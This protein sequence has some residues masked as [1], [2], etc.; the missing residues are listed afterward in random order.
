MKHGHEPAQVS[1]SLHLSL[2]QSRLEII[3]IAIGVLALVSLLGII[4]FL[5][6]L[7]RLST[8][9][10]HIIS[11]KKESI[12]VLGEAKRSLPEEK[13]TFQLEDKVNVDGTR[14]KSASIKG[15]HRELQ[16]LHRRST[17][18]SGHEISNEYHQ[19]NLPVSAIGNIHPLQSSE[20]EDSLPGVDQS[21]LYRRVLS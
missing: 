21:M 6:T 20:S 5:S 10:Q 2:E 14:R 16:S 8:S 4:V 12:E 7:S 15:S 13:Q 17:V 9:D 19:N 18:A 11:A 1:A 3:L